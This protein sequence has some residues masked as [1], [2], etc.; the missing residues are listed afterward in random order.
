LVLGATNVPWELDRDISLYFENKIFIPLPELY[1]R[2]KLLRN[3]LGNTPHSLT[4]EDFL[5]IGEACIG[6][7]VSDIINVVKEAMMM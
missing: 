6:Y 2:K 7:S 5:L 4:E 3:R 1:T